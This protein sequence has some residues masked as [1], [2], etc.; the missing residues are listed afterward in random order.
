MKKIY[1]YMIAAA[2]VLAIIIVAMIIRP[3]KVGTLNSPL[4]GMPS[5]ARAQS[6]VSAKYPELKT[7]DKIFGSATALLKIF[8]YEDYT[9]IYSAKLAETLDRIRVES[10]DKVAIVIRPYFKN[11]P[12]ASQAQAAVD[13]AGE[14]NKW[15]EMRALLF[16]QTSNKQLN[17]GNFSS[18]AEQIGLNDG[19]FTACLTKS[20]KSVKI[21]QLVQ[22][23]ETYT[24]QGAPTV[25]AGEEM[26]LGA[27]P[28]DDF[29]DSNGD[30]IEGLKTVV[31]RLIK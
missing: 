3:E 2:A 12:L 26:I 28:Y 29:T 8:V 20:Q 18:Y 15:I 11:S 13:C 17:A 21:E 4:V 9:N 30:K 31:V 24:V 1:M 25:F 23:A 27:R 5:E 7:E 6:F 10:D 16:A 22:E 19:D 14:Q